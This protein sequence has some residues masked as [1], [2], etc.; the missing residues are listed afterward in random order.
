[1]RYNLVFIKHPFFKIFFLSVPLFKSL[2]L[3]VLQ[4][5]FCFMFW[6]FGQETCGFLAF[7]SGTEPTVPALEGEVFTTRQTGRSLNISAKELII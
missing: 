3:N 7:R 4:Y 1:M 2:L 5:Y 6:F